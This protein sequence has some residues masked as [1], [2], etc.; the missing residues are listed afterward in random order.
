LEVGNQAGLRAER[1]IMNLNRVNGRIENVRIV[2][3][4]Q[5]IVFNP[6]MREAAG[7]SAIVFAAAGMGSAAVQTS[8][9]ASDAAD[10][11]TLYSFEIDGSMFAGC[12]RKATFRS[13]DEVEIVFHRKH[14]GNEV[15]A[16][17]RP[18]TR[19]IW[20]YPY[21]SRGSGAAIRHGAGLWWR[22]SL[23][24]TVFVSAV[25]AL[26]FAIEGFD[27]NGFLFATTM[28]AITSFLVLGKV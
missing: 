23:A 15:L 28:A 8:M 6:Q 10:D 18:S 20:L 1:R 19:S 27:L 12:T 11:V 26:A 5:D 9:N 16:V 2:E 22:S 3:H 13:G 21:M 14:E 24:G 17:R 4:G 7:I 25:C